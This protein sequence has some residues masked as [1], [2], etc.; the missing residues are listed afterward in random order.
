M[1][2]R[3]K[4]ELQATLMASRRRFPP[5]RPKTPAD[6]RRVG[7]GAH[8]GDA[9][10]ERATPTSQRGAPPRAADARGMPLPWPGAAPRRSARERGR[11]GSPVLQRGRLAT[12]CRARR[13]AARPARLRRA[14]GPHHAWT[15]P[16][17]SGTRHTGSR[18]REGP[19]GARW[20]RAAGGAQR[21]PAGRLRWSERRL[22]DSDR[23]SPDRALPRPDAPAMVLP[24]PRLWGSVTRWQSISRPSPIPPTCGRSHMSH[25]VREDGH[26]DRVARR[27]QTTQ[28]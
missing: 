23:V 20:Q 24:A 2:K 7:H 16:I 12:A 10:P 21:V 28:A 3:K 13:C 4:T 22:W 8:G 6:G 19:Q 15:R 5:V 1:A 18:W 14:G 17:P 25:A 9:A 11:P 26:P 27:R